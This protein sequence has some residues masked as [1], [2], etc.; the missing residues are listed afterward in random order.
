MGGCVLTGIRVLHGADVVKLRRIRGPGRS[1]AMVVSVSKGLAH[2]PP[3][4]RVS[5]EALLCSHTEDWFTRE[6][7]TGHLHSSFNF[8]QEE[9]GAKGLAPPGSQVALPQAPA[10]RQ[11]AE[12]FTSTRLRP[13][14]LS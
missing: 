2:A 3:P 4:P 9:R 10:P 12:D 1:E 7:L 11:R 14:Q 13:R 8:V 6:P 5:S